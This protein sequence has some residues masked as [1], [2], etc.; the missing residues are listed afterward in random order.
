MNELSLVDRLPTDYLR[1]VFAEM[2]RELEVEHAKLAEGLLYPVRSLSATTTAVPGDGL[3][4]CNA[5]GAAFT[6][7]LPQAAR[8]KEKALLLKKTDASANAVLIDA[9]ASETIDGSITVS[10]ASQ[11]DGV[12]LVSDGTQ[13]LRM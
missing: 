3:L 9:N 10:L 13:W 1:S 4:V 5:T 8:C 2:M 6:V 7:F 11:W 12:L